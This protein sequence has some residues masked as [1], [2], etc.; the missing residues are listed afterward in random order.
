MDANEVLETLPITQWHGPFDTA[1]RRHAV[2]ALAS[3]GFSIYRRCR[4]A[5]QTKHSC[6]I[7]GDG[8]RP[9]HQPRSDN[10]TG[11]QFRAGGEPA[12]R[13][14]SMINGLPV[15]HTADE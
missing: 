3:A 7:R 5:C 9:K 13:L 2:D 1:L 4:S 10:R 8:Q 11:K 12:E 15:C 6:W 14:A